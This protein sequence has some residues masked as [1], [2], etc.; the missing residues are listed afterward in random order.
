VL[1]DVGLVVKPAAL[2]EWREELEQLKDRLGELFVRPEPRRQAG[3]YLE[4]LLSSTERK[5]GWQLAEQIGDTRP[6]KSSIT[7]L[8]EPGQSASSMLPICH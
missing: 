4:A 2:D 6:P 3:L 7:R 8:V 5:N 1:F